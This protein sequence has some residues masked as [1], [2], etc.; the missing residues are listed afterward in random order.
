MTRPGQALTPGHAHAPAL[1]LSEALS[2]WGGIDAES[3][4]IIDRSHPDLG[5]GITGTVL[6]M[7]GGRGSS[8]SS[9]V[10]AECLRR[11][12]GPAAIILSRPDPIL[13]VGAIV[14]RTLYGV[15]CPIVVSA[16]EGLVTGVA[17]EVEADVTGAA[18]LT[19]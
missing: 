4:R 12:T 17:V 1:V 18:V 5:A 7:P 6:V 16:I 9:S 3:G 10:L 14:A 11:G 8:S 19:A 15:A 2:F 13:A